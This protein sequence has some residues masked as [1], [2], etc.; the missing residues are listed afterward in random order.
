MPKTTK[1]KTEIKTE[2]PKKEEPKVING[3]VTC[4]RLNV[5]S[6]P[7]IKSDVVKVILKG[8][9]VRVDSDT[10]KEWLKVVLKDKTKGYC[11]KEFIKIEK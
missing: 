5:R 2:S 11:M 3:T 9:T 1:P 7:D 6:K 4:D 8:D 10:D